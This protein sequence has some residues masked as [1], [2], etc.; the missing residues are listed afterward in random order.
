MHHSTRCRRCKIESRA[1]LTNALVYVLERLS[2]LRQASYKVNRL[3]ES[4][5]NRGLFFWTF[6][7]VLFVGAMGFVDYFTGYE[8]SFSLFYLAPIVAVTW[9]ANRKLGLMIS[10]L[11]AVTWLVAEIA[12]GQKYSY[13]IIHLW[14]TLIRFGFFLIVT[15]LVSELRKAHELQRALARTDH[16]SGAVNA[17]YFNELMEIEISRARRYHHPFTVAYL[18]LDNFKVVND[19]LGHDTGDEVIRYIGNELK[20]LLR[21]T[22]IVARLGGDQ[23]ALLLL[24]VGQPQAQLVISKLYAQVTERLRQKN[25]PLTFSMGVVICISAPA[26]AKELLRMADQLMYVVK[27]TTKND[28]QFAIYP[29][30]QT[31][32]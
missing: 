4:L 21:S 7:G 15:Y 11:S 1:R 2:K 20:L 13:P 16:I 19:N 25:W 28:I 26:S 12:A 27:R 3:F 18:D 32:E 14:N 6:A 8:I 10:I 22:D 24:D 17:R 31:T 30:K 9:F 29:V 5:E 23:F